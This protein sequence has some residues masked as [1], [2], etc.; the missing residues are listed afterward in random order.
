[1]ICHFDEG[2]IT[3]REQRTVCSANVISPP[4]KM[5]IVIL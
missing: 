3:S 4:L 1:M 2:E 5:H